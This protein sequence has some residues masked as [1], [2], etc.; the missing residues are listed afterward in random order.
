MWGKVAVISGCVGT[1]LA[2]IEA[3]RRWRPRKGDEAQT[4]PAPALVITAVD[5]PGGS[6]S[7]GADA[8]FM[9][10]VHLAN[11]GQRSAGIS[12]VM[13]GGAVEL[14]RKGPFSIA[15]GAGDTWF[16]NVGRAPMRWRR[17]F[18]GWDYTGEGELAVEL[19]DAHGATLARFPMPR[20]MAM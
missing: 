12:V 6:M 17:G 18:T 13:Y 19:Q 8:T 10:P 4:R 14:G 1:A 3:M 2:A 16:L 7:E 11:A 15:S 20:G 5:S 9:F